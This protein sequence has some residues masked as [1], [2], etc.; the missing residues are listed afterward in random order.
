MT[1]LST[2]QSQRLQALM[3]SGEFQSETD[4]LNAM[5]SQFEYQQQLKQLKKE[6]EIGIESG[7]AREIQNT[8]H[9]CDQL[10]QKAM[11]RVNNG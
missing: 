9:F 7:A 2:Q 4:L 1:T 5:L 6:I 10:L 3:L 11:A 8:A